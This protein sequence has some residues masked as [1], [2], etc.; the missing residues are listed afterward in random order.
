MSNAV[1]KVRR[2]SG[3]I[4]DVPGFWGRT[5][6][7]RCRGVEIVRVDRRHGARVGRGLDQLCG[8]ADPAAAVGAG[9][10]A[11]EQRE[12]N[13]AAGSP[14]GRCQACSAWSPSPGRRLVA[15][16]QWGSLRRHADDASPHART[17]AGLWVGLPPSRRLVD[18]AGRCRHARRRQVAAGE[19]AERARRVRA[20]R[21]TEAPCPLPARTL[22]ASAEFQPDRTILRRPPWSSA[23]HARRRSHDS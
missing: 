19:R 17:P 10:V 1:A 14:S 18:V 12:R 9:P 2:D 8:C 3:N 16:R 15:A 13:I 6:C 5:S 20:A 4:G 7:D 11:A 23:P 21:R 22:R